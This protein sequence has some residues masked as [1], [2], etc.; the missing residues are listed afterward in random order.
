MTCIAHR[1]ILVLAFSCGLRLAI[2]PELSS[3]RSLLPQALTSVSFGV[4]TNFMRATLIMVMGSA[5][6]CCAGK[7]G[8]KQARVW[9]SLDCGST[10]ALTARLQVVE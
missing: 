6:F 9:N 5:C 4:R 2:D 3:L 8:Q 10:M 7:E 1:A